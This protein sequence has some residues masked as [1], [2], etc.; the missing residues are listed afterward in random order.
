[1]SPKEYQQLLEKLL[2]EGQGYGRNSEI[3]AIPNQTGTHYF[4]T[5]DVKKGLQYLQS[6]TMPDPATDTSFTLEKKTRINHDFDPADPSNPG[7][8]RM[9][10]NAGSYRM[11]I[12]VDQETFLP[13]QWD[14]K[15]FVVPAG[16]YVLVLQREIEGLSQAIDAIKKGETTPERALYKTSDFGGKTINK[17][18]VYGSDR[19]LDIFGYGPVELTPETNT[20]TKRFGNVAARGL[21]FTRRNAHFVADH[22]APERASFKKRTRSAITPV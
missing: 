18:D 2:R 9:K 14:D 20:I 21:P 5:R 7:N 15:P 22:T 4:V 1:M 13:V 8:G 10:P 17:F 11:A 6:G 19:D 3:V 12:K 16:G